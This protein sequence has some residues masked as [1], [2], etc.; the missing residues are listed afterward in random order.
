MKQ[1]TAALFAF[2]LLAAHTSQ[3]CSMYK[4]TKDGKTIV[5]NNE[6]F[7][8]PNGQFWYEAGSKG[9]HGVLYMGFLNNFAQGAINEAGLMFDGFFQPY[10]EVKN[11]E[12]KTNTPIAEALRHVMQTMATVEEASD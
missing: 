12:G 5:G 2:F 9:Q 1:L 8:S 11:T 7:L 6:D 4:L 10:L 3:A